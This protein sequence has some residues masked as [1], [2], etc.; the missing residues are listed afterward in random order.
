VAATSVEDIG[1]NGM[2]TTHWDQFRGMDLYD[3]TGEKIGGFDTVYLDDE[4]GQPE[5]LGIRTGFF[6]MNESFVPAD[7]VQV[8]DGR[9][10]THFTKDEVKHTPNLSP[11]EYLTREEEEKLYGHFGRTYTPGTYRADPRA[12]ESVRLRRYIWID[13]DS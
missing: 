5:F 10:V 13:S 11:S 8:R 3:G 7:S 4:T 6:G 1:G 12:A 2:T 9:L